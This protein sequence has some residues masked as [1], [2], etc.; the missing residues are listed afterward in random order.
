MGRRLSQAGERGTRLLRGGSLPRP[1]G[2]SPPGAALPPVGTP[3]PAG[4]RYALQRAAGDR[5]CKPDRAALPAPGILLPRKDHRQG[6]AQGRVPS[7]RPL[8]VIFHGKIRRQS[9]GR[10]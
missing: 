7:G 6:R 4:N 2:G 5:A 9:E 10:T 3:A 8:T 1:T